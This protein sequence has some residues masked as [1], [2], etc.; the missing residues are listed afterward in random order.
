MVVG[1]LLIS[2]SRLYIKFMHYLLVCECKDTSKQCYGCIEHRAAVVNKIIELE[3]RVAS[4]GKNL[5]IDEANA[6]HNLKCN[7]YMLEN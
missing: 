4:R 2:D 5:G 7:H 1:E 3:M 6:L